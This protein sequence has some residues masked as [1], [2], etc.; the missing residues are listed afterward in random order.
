MK[1]VF[2]SF[3]SDEDYGFTKTVVPVRL[4][5]YG[6]EKLISRSQAK[7]L[8]AR[9]DRFKAVIFDFDGIES[10][11]QAFADEVFRVF[12]NHHPEIEIHY[13]KATD[14]VT[15]MITRAQSNK[16]SLRENN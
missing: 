16:E 9:I 12:K 7:R 13:V 11:G 3:S 4:V 15:Q 2:D 5:Q 1:S 6:D 10:V 8:L 14:E